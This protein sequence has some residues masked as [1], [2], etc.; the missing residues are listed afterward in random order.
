MTQALIHRDPIMGS[1]TAP[2]SSI[3][4]GSKCVLACALDVKGG[5]TS[6]LTLTL[7]SVVIVSVSQANIFLIFVDRRLLILIIY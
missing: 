5:E 4:F 1:N 7:V 2:Q 3:G 6:L